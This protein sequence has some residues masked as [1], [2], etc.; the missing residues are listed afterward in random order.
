MND[1]QDRPIAVHKQQTYPSIYVCTASAV[2]VPL[3]SAAPTGMEETVCEQLDREREGLPGR[4]IARN[5]TMRMRFRSRRRRDSFGVG[6]SCLAYRRAGCRLQPGHLTPRAQ[7]DQV[8]SCCDAMFIAMDILRIPTP[9]IDV[10][11]NTTQIKSSNERMRRS[12]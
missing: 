8:E 6:C 1:D 3:L 5:E 4:S 2:V 11:T 9:I 7:T 10:E 12:R